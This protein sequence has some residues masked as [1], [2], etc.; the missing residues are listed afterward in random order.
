MPVCVLYGVPKPLTVTL[1]W[2]T[3]MLLSY[4]PAGPAWGLQ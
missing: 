1:M 4:M 3:G 2:L